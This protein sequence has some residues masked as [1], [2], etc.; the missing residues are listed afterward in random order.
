MNQIRL[1]MVLLVLMSSLALGA[2]EAARPTPSTA[3]SQQ[4]IDILADIVRVLRHA[5]GGPLPATRDEAAAVVAQSMGKVSQDVRVAVSPS[6]YFMLGDMY[7]HDWGA[8]TKPN[9]VVT[10]RFWMDGVRACEGKLSFECLSYGASLANIAAPDPTEF[11]AFHTRIGSFLAAGSIDDIY[12]FC[13]LD[14]VIGQRRFVLADEHKLNTVK[15][16]RE[17]AAKY[18]NVTTDEGT[19][20]R[21]RVDARSMRAIADALKGTP[22]GDMAAQSTDG[23]K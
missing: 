13:P 8:E 2:A 15:A 17:N 16:I 23:G 3:V 12:G 6:V 9:V 5:E 7:W 18:A 10:R 22:I 1:P 4:D 19:L 14:M 11:I 21:Y 20:R